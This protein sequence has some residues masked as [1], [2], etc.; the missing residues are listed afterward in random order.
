MP[1]VSQLEG[2]QHSPFLDGITISLQLW[3]D[4]TR[5]CQALA[6]AGV[7]TGH[8]GDK[9]A[10]HEQLAHYGTAIGAERGAHRDLTLALVGEGSLT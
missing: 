5:D 2:P 4:K 6:A 7:P 9:T 3:I 8:T 1:P 10:L